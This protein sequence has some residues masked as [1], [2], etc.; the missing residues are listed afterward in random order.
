MGRGSRRPRRRHRRWS[1]L[2]RPPRPRPAA[3]GRPGPWLSHVPRGTCSELGGPY[4]RPRR[5]SGTATPA[6]RDGSAGA[7]GQQAPP[8]AGAAFAHAPGSR[9]RAGAPP[10]RGS[11][12]HGFLFPGDSHP[13][14]SR[15]TEQEAQLACD[16]SPI[17][18]HLLQ[19]TS[20]A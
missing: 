2:T 17:R 9:S 15:T 7:R 13:Y 12:G 4:A 10:A 11:G 8:R 19:S 20:R 18:H 3:P 1:G 16:L 5:T 6:R 14:L